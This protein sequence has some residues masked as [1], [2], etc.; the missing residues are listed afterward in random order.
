MIEGQPVYV[1][2]ADLDG[3]FSHMRKFGIGPSA[4]E[5]CVVKFDNGMSCHYARHELE[6]RV[7]RLP[8]VPRVIEGGLNGR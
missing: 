2:C 3:T 8:F 7:T 1:K 4:F 5:L 6:T